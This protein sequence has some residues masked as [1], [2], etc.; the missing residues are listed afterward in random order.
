MVSALQNSIRA[1]RVSHA[2][3]FTG[4]PGSGKTSLAH[5]FAKTL[6]C[7]AGGASPCCSC[8]SCR[9]YESGNHPDMLYVNPSERKSIGVDDV[10]EQIISRISTAPERYRYKIFIADRADLLT[11]EAQN[12]LLKTIEEPAGFAVFIFLARHAEDLLPTVRSRCV[13]FA[14]RPLPAETVEA[15]LIR[16]GINGGT[17]RA[18]SHASHGSI[19]AALE[20]AASEN[21]SALGEAASQIAA[22]TSSQNINAAFGMYK[23]FEPYKE[24]KEQAVSLLDMLY[25]RYRDEITERSAANGLTASDISKIFF[26]CADAVLKAKKALQKNANYQ[27]TIEMLLLRIAGLCA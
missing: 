10:K 8:L 18:C 3:L 4:A 5:A 7:E 6:Q 1:G 27:L 2:F 25:M 21:F 19:G 23:L 24:N 13:T 17:A 20:M 16:R 15:E 22:S 12:K 14:L 11:D 9:V 26:V